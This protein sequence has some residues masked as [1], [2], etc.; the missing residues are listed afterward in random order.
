MVSKKLQS[1]SELLGFL[2]QLHSELDVGGHGDL[3]Q[4]VLAASRFA[5]GSASEFLHEAHTALLRVDREQPAGLS[6]EQKRN[7]RMVLA[8]IDEAFDR[9]GGA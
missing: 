3:A 4:A 1:D 9:I 8:Q 2:S 7:L 5:V 6:A